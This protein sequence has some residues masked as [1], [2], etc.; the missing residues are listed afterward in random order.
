M[1]ERTRNS[2]RE[3]R[4]G[5]STAVAAFAVALTF[6]MSAASSAAAQSATG[7]TVQTP[8]GKVAV[9]KVVVN[10]LGVPTPPA[11][12]IVVHC[13]ANAAAQATHTPVAVPGGQTVTLPSPI[14]HGI[15]C[16]VTETVPPPISKVEACKG[17]GA[18]WTVSY[19]SPVTIAARETSLLTVTNTLNCDTP[20]T[21]TG[22]LKVI[23]SVNNMTNGSVTLPTTY[24]MS[25]TCTPS[26]PTSQSLATPPGPAGATIGN[27]AASS[28][29]V[30]TEAALA[31]IT[32][33][34][35][36]NGGSASWTTMGSPSGPVTIPSGGTATVTIRNT[37]RCDPPADSEYD[38][39][40]RK[41][42]EDGTLTPGQTATFT[43]HPLNHGPSPVGSATGVT[44]TDTLPASFTPPVT[45]TGTGPGWTCVV[46]G[47]VVT[48]VYNGPAVAA[49][50][51][52]PTI[53]ITAV[54]GREGG[55]RNCAWITMNRRI[56]TAADKPIK[57]TNREDNASCVDGRVGGG[58]GG[59]DHDVGISKKGP[60]GAVMV[61]QAATF[62]LSAVNTGPAPVNAGTGATVTDTLPAN[63]TAPITAT[64]NSPGWSCSVAGRVVTCV[65]TGAAVG[66]HENF[67]GI[68][69]TAVAGREGGYSNCTTIEFNPRRGERDAPRPGGR[70]IKDENPRDNK[71][72]VE[73]R[74]EAGKKRLN[75]NI[76]KLGGGTVAAG[77]PIT[78]S[79]DVFN[80]GPDA[81]PG[82]TVV[83]TLPAGLTSVVA[84]TGSPWNCTQSGSVLTCVYSG[85]QIAQNLHFPAVN[86]Q[87]TAQT[88]GSFSNCAKVT[89][90]GASDSDM[91]DNR[92][93]RAYEVTRGPAGPTASIRI[94][95]DASPDDPQDFQFTATGTGVYDFVLDD[96]PSNG[97]R[98]NS[99]TF[100]N[101]MPG[102]YNFS[103][104]AMTGWISGG[105]GYGGTVNCTDIPHPTRSTFTPTT[106]SVSIALV[107]GDEVTCTFINTKRPATTG[108]GTVTIIK[109]AAPDDAQDFFFL[110]GTSGGSFVL[111]DDG[112]SNNPY[113]NQT[114][115]PGL[116]AGP[117]T[118]TENVVSGWNL[119]G[120]VCTPATGTTPDVANRK[121][122]VNVTNG[123]SITC[124]FTNAK[125]PP[126]GTA[127]L[128]IIKDAAPD[129]AQDFHYTVSGP[130]ISNF[131]LDDDPSN[132]ARPKSI[133]F[134]GLATGVSFTV[135]EDGV[136]GWTVPSLQCIP[137]IIGTST[138]YTDQLN[139][140]MT[141]SMAPGVHMT[142]TFK[143]VK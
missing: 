62:T 12:N 135:T 48:C 96:D 115:L 123:A 140:T 143:N 42:S 128:T 55:Y 100:S 11:F 70:V 101:L 67:P 118:F 9:R 109:D 131:W 5:L 99:I 95:K 8:S 47:L 126:A 46:S 14:L 65:W 92:D 81:V 112:I 111:D 41:S 49:H 80:L 20:T 74:V 33:V 73:G 142:C 69:I 51:P 137:D 94:I 45:A 105:T 104:G 22:S 108:F 79:F 10:T 44:V 121:V 85:G 56:Y 3:P 93:C 103:E 91:Q 133:T 50:Q 23:K 102:T 37:L 77:S 18:T 40:I 64:G 26:G 122:T 116:A 13:S 136:P 28:Q 61:G 27:I 30:V 59:Q 29:C 66:P 2:S 54:A 39:G 113:P 35:A 60:S 52:L 90:N 82:I 107:A 130:G 76:R 138:T 117:W 141:V 106:S 89:I 120:I 84:P 6:G 134:T 72:C 21:K 32:N 110:F 98:P 97:A 25:V 129:D 124:K 34:K 17:N 87:A 38:V 4:P 83:D 7:G 53:K 125:Q 127:T 1:H 71:D 139:R 19:S 15:I 88:P 68:T 132:G 75:V 86:I 78:F 43:L 63:F 16:S 114:T 119:T 57:D 36:C 58:G 31:P 24:L